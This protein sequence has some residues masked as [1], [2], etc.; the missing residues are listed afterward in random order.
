MVKTDVQGRILKSVPAADHHGDVCY[1]NGR[2]YCAVNLGRFNRPAGEE[3]SWV[4]VYDGE[5]L[6]ELARHPVKELVHGAGGIAYHGGRFIVIGGL[7][8]D[9]PENYVYEYDEQFRFVKRHVLASGYTLMGIQTAAYANGAW[10]FGC[11][12]KPQMLLRADD[13]FRLT[14]KWEFNASV[15]I[16]GIPGGKFLIAT[17]EVKDKQN[18]A[19]LTIA[20]EDPD[21]GLATKRER[22]VPAPVP[23]RAP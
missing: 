18:T 14:G 5:T 17:N 20:T 13:E 16:V 11:Y 15:G 23:V 8:P 4:Y 12:G 21:K 2:L 7:P 10:W 9:V 19:Y 6:A 22:P 3:D 1:H